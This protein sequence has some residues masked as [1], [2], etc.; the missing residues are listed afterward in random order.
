MTKNAHFYD[1]RQIPLPEV[2][3]EE[4]KW[5][6]RINDVA[7]M[8]NGCVRATS[9]P[10]SLLGFNDQCLR[11][12]EIDG[13]FTLGGEPA[14]KTTDS[15]GKQEKLRKSPINED[16]WLLIMSTEQ[17]TRDAGLCRTGNL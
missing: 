2:N 11:V 17:T 15:K 1:E 5:Y 6:F 3:T 14:F 7:R 4:K 8:Q 10:P 16:A 12:G 13:P 9:N